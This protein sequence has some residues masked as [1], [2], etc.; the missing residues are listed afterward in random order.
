MILLK[1]RFKMRILFMI[2]LKKRFKIKLILK[3]VTHKI[4]RINNFVVVNMLSHVLFS[5]FYFVYF[6]T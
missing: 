3:R 4:N 2:L 1:K 5:T 6:T